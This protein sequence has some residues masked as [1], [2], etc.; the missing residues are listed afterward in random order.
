MKKEKLNILVINWQDIKNPKGGGAEIHFHNIFSRIVKMGHEVTLLC[1]KEDQFPDYEVIDGIKTYRHGSRNLFNYTIPSQ[2][3]RLT[4]E[5]SFDIVIDDLNKIPFFTPLYVK[6]P[7]LGISHH[8]FGSSIFRE[9]NFL[10]GTYVYLAEKMVD[11][12]YKQIPFAV[13]SDS[14]LQEFIKRGFDI[15]KFSM[16]PNAIDHNLFPMTVSEKYKIPTI[17]YFGRL[18]RYKSV[19]HLL[20]AFKLVKKRI[21]EAEVLIMGTGSYRNELEL[22]AK[23]L[24]IEESTRFT[25]FVTEEEKVNYLSKVH[26]VV[27][28]SMKEGWG[29][30]NIEA[31]ACGTPVISADVPGLRDSV[32]NGQSGLLYEYNNIEQLA[33]SIEYLLVDK[34]LQENLSRGSLEWA[35]QFSWNKS[36][37]MMLDVIYRTIEKFKAK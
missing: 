6:E 10:F 35:A 1:C 4:K 24:E 33:K 37:E 26:C 21:P 25:G 7:L 27:N 18:R 29:I 30:T 28:T 13:V 8:F 20:R 9:T 3:K 36:A 32:K 11:W 23:K 2:Y 31:N 16:V 22:L 34:E 5:N 12:F 19:D 15:N 17:A 14:T